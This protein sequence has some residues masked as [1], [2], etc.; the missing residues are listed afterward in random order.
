MFAGMLEERAVIELS[1][2]LC[3]SCGLVYMKLPK[4]LWK[5]LCKMW[6]TPVKIPEKSQD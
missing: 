2:Y 4:P 6:T 1:V 3:G 5:T